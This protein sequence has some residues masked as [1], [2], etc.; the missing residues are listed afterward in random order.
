M[1]QERSHPSRG[2]HGAHPLYLW[3]R[4]S[5]RPILTLTLVALTLVVIVAVCASGQTNEP[6]WPSPG[7][8]HLVLAH[9][10]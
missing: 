4:I 8:S 10:W 6:V 7:A 9:F 3:W 2:K 5:R 1:L